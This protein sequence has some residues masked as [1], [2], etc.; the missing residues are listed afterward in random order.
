MVIK[1][2]QI[3][4]FGDIK[5]YFH[6]LKSDF[7]IIEDKDVLL[8]LRWLLNQT[9]CYS[10]FNKKLKKDSKIIIDFSH[11][12]N[13]FT[14][15]YGYD[16]EYDLIIAS[17]KIGNY[18]AKGFV[19]E[20]IQEDFAKQYN[21]AYAFNDG[22]NQSDKIKGLIDEL[23]KDIEKETNNSDFFVRDNFGHTV[24]SKDILKLIEEFIK[25]NK[26]VKLTKDGNAMS[27]K[28]DGTWVYLTKKGEEKT[29]FSNND[30][31]ELLNVEFF[32][33]NNELINLIRQKDKEFNSINSP[34]ISKHTKFFLDLG[35]KRQIIFYK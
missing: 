24:P 7:E 8:V 10:E 2:V 15:R 32:L 19:A 23:K 9:E 13:D 21:S 26:Y 29:T 12:D 33:K 27:L 25:E 30:V 35:V 18:V 4:N 31:K 5:T 16:S 28:D 11:N 22:S 34:L 20:Q 1:S 6:T 17:I 3:E 14:F